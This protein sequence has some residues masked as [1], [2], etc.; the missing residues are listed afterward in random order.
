VC[1]EG[2]EEVDDRASWSWQELNLCKQVDG[3]WGSREV[4]D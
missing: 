4:E 1:W 2:E 3:I